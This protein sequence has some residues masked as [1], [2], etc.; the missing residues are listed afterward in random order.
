MIFDA[1]DVAISFG[2]MGSDIAKSQS[3]I[4]LR[5]DNFESILAPISFGKNVIR[6]VKKYLTFLLTSHITLH[7][8]SLLST[9]IIHQPPLNAM[10]LL[11]INVFLDISAVVAIASGEPVDSL[12][13]TDPYSIKD[14]LL[15]PEMWGDVLLLS[16]Y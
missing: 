15:T 2:I 10:Q 6:S 14:K 13:E 9:A 12:L 4:E 3:A 1:C 8:I 11:W 5:D 7:S 16:L